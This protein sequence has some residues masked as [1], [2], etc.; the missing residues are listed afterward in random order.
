MTASEEQLRWQMAVAM[1]YGATSLNHYVYTSHDDDYEAIVEYET[2]AP[3]E[4]YERVKAVNLELQSWS[5]I[6]MSYSWLGTAKV[7]V[8]DKNLML[9]KLSY[10]IDVDK[11]GYLSEITSDKDLLVGA[12]ENAEHQYAYMIA[13]AGDA[14]EIKGIDHL[15]DFTMEAASVTLKLKQGEY[16]CVA[17]VSDGEISYLPV[18]ADNSISIQ[19][20]AYDGAFVIPIAE[21]YVN[22]YVVKT[23]DTT[24]M[25]LLFAAFVL[26][27]VGVAGVAVILRKKKYQ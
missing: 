24:R 7:D 9:N 20:G 2:F 16:Q 14:A 5:D 13:N 4:L 27:C 11:Y 10:N 18:D 6:Y 26:S 25:D 23:A 1:A 19:L 22:T 21:S 15:A 3:T 12:F 8:G 17:V